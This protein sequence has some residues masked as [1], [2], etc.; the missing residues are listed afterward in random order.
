M[1]DILSLMRIKHYIKNLLIFLPLFFSGSFMNGEL[2]V[3]NIIG[4]ISFCLLT[5]TIYIFNDI[6]DANKDRLHTT[7]CNRP[8]ASGRISKRTA[9]LLIVILLSISVLLALNIFSGN[10]YVFVIMFSYLVLNILYSLKLKNIPIIDVSII[11]AGFILRLIYGGVI[12][13]IPISN[14]LYLTVIAISFYMGYGKRRNEI[15][16]QKEGTR[17]VL[18]NYSYEFLDKNMHM[19]SA[20]A[21]IFYALWCVENSTKYAINLVYSVPLVMLIVMK[22]SLDIERKSDGDPVNVILNDKWLMLLT[23]LYGILLIFEVYC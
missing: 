1:K 20:L 22:Y 10:I 15:L 8:I 14:W 19:S 3:T 6:C 2:V 16:M 5:S 13:N 17:K 23:V 11:V 7:K 9:I 21:I 12:S 4:F 18:E